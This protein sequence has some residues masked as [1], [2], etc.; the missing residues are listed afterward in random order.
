MCADA[1]EFNESY[2]HMSELQKIESYCEEAVRLG[3]ATPSW[4]QNRLFYT[5]WYDIAKP[6]PFILNK[7]DA[8]IAGQKVT[9]PENLRGSAFFDWCE[10]NNCPVLRIE[11]K[12]ESA[13]LL[14]RF[15]NNKPKF[16]LEKVRKKSSVG[17]TE[18]DCFEIIYGVIAHVRKEY[19]HEDV[20][21][22]KAAL[23]KETL[24]TIGHLYNRKALKALKRQPIKEIRS[25]IIQAS[26]DMAGDELSN[27]LTLPLD[28]SYSAETGLEKEVPTD[29]TIPLPKRPDYEVFSELKF[30]THAVK[31]SSDEQVGGSCSLVKAICLEKEKS[32]KWFLKIP[33]NSP[34]P[35]REFEQLDVYDIHTE[36]RCGFFDVEILEKDCLYGTLN[37][38][39]ELSENILKNFVLR[40][41]RGQYDFLLRHYGL[42]LREFD[43]GDSAF[44][45]LSGRK[46]CEI[47][48]PGKGADHPELDPFQQR[49]LAFATNDENPVT[50]IQG[51]P[52]TGKSRCLV[53]LVQTL[54]RKGMRILLTAPSHTA[55]D[56]ICRQLD[57]LPVLR[58]GRR[59]GK[60]DARVS[61]RF[62]ANNETSRDRFGKKSLEHCGGMIFA[63]TPMGLLRS[64]Q[65][66]TS[67]D[68]EG[69]FDILI[70]DE[71]G[72]AEPLLLFPCTY[73]AQRCVLFGDHQQLPPFQQSK[74]FYRNLEK[75]CG[76]IP[77]KWKS[78]L[79][80]G[81]L[82]W[83]AKRGFPSIML[84]RCYRCQNPRLMRFSSTLLY[85]A[86]VKTSAEAEYYKLSWKQRRILFPPSSLRCLS[87]SALPAE[88]KNEIILSEDGRHGIANPVEA[89]LVIKEIYKLLQR[90]PL[91]EISV[92]TPYRHHTSIIRRFLDLDE[93]L[94]A[95]GADTAFT[96]REWD[97]FLKTRIASV[98]SF[99][100]GESDAVIISYVRSNWQQG[101]GFVDNRNRI[102][103]AHSRSRREMIVVGD[104]KCLKAQAA[105]PVFRKMQ[106]A[107]RQDGEFHEV[108][109][110][111]VDLQLFHTIC[112]STIV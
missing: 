46:A 96:I 86:R 74:A 73:L 110:E 66:H 91:N 98:D 97:N 67:I 106:N 1:K 92:I 18:G 59:F 79:S 107:F 81:V 32:K 38:P 40:T 27:Q 16:V 31:V 11:N 44:Q 28:G 94:D 60:I 25:K 80:E 56:N 2:N 77:E 105:S 69:L 8:T 61:S 41:P 13:C 76:S 21:K 19:P 84:E 23:F 72:M 45:S 29:E 108:L 51:P 52:G 111:E 63:G 100:G 89:T 30:L 5:F 87:T 42:L 99:Q 33:L 68:N 85:G 22:L 26:V 37:S 109:P 62:N 103:V 20:R 57:E 112:E 7:P 49:A 12:K 104:M 50:M 83:A 75:Q 14:I 10:E 82:E 17:Y 88:M 101:I 47:T 78:M 9:F 102:N 53:S 54:C 90:Y 70:C 55:V 48:V 71:A 95:A 3:K 15:E 24:E 39:F 43:Q 34:L 6:D 4:R 93:A 58:S 35:I 64:R 36:E 65:L